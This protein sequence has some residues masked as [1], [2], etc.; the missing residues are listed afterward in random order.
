MVVEEW[1][2]PVDAPSEVSVTATGLR[3][4]DPL[5]LY[6]ECSKKDTD[7]IRYLDAIEQLKEVIC[8]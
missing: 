7:G 3:S 4:V 1:S 8:R 6:V 5:N 2:Y